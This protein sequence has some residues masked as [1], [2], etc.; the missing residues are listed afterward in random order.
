MIETSLDKLLAYMQAMKASGDT[1]IDKEDEKALT[2]I[3][4]GVPGYSGDKHFS[5]FK[6][7][8]AATE[9]KNILILGVYHGRDI[10]LIADIAARHHPNRPFSIVGVDKF[11]STPCDDWPQASVGKT[12][13][14]AGMGR[15]PSLE[16]AE[17]NLEKYQKTADITLF[18]GTD[19]AFIQ[20]TD[21]TFDFVYLDTSHDFATVWRQLR[22]IKRVCKADTLIC[23]DDYSDGG[24]WGVKRAVTLGFT[25][26]ACF[27][28]WIWMGHATLLQP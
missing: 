14:E 8:L 5:F 17:R 12:W 26:H 23:G 22:T 1:V 10:A 21:R 18:K 28:D 6:C 24:A 13:E 4:E 2:E 25:K 16:E 7:L 3:I 27:T 9:I 11:E 19:E 20:G 15:P